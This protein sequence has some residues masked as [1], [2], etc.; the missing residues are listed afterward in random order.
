MQKS[1]YYIINS[2]T[3][4]RLIAAPFLLLL[5]FLRETD[6]F[7]WLLA[8]SFF[9]DA[10]DGYLARRYKVVSVMGAK[11]DSWGDDLTVI[12]GTIGLFVIRPEF[13]RKEY[14]WLLFVFI[15]FLV[16]TISALV[17]YKKITSFHTLLA[18]LAAILQGCF[19]ILS[20]FVT[21]PPL[22]LFYTAVSVTALQLTEEI[23]LI[24]LLPEW[25]ANVKGLYWLL[26][27][28]KK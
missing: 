3:L 4:Y 8:F 11:L 19:L 5:V 10:I 16:E 25:K 23:V 26:R 21:E 22:L 12:A 9:T 6:S 1:S 18:K 27:Q 24:F 28:K 7:K 17:R 20:F 13:I 14:I 2:I 15:I